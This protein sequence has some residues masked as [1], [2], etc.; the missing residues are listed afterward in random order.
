MSTTLGWHLLV[1]SVLVLLGS[2]L[3]ILRVWHRRE[4]MPRRYG[5]MLLVV[6]GGLACIA[7]GNVLTGWGFAVGETASASF[8]T[9]GAVFVRGVLLTI[10][11]YLLVK[12]P[13][14]L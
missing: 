6:G 2:L 8:L 7:L 1:V 13:E 10:T 5:E 9:A 11:V 3:F 12:R 14:L 4:Q